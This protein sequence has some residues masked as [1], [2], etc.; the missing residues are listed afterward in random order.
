MEKTKTAKARTKESRAKPK[1]NKH[2]VKKTIVPRGKSGFTQFQKAAVK[3]MLRR[4]E[5]E[6][7]IMDLAIKAG[8]STPTI[9]NIENGTT[10]SM[11]TKTLEDL[12]KALNWTLSDFFTV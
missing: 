2:I 5:L 11:Q 6:L 7:S 3:I 4:Q 12:C 10:T 9:Y 8:I 1:T